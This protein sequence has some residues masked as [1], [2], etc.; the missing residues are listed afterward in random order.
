MKTIR[1]TLVKEGAQATCT[2]RY[3]FDD[4]PE[5]TTWAGNREAFKANG[6]LLDF[7]DGILNLEEQVRHQSA[8]CAATYKI[9]D[10]GGEALMWLD[11]VTP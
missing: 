7:T 8:L 1:I 3:H 2:H 4:F 10:L 9:E 6:R 5:D 11:N